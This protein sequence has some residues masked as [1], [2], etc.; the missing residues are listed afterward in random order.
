MLLG[1]RLLCGGFGRQL[2]YGILMSYKLLRHFVLY[3]VIYNPDKNP[4]DS[5]MPPLVS[6]L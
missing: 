6:G 2:N 3:N 1:G 5:T 4:T